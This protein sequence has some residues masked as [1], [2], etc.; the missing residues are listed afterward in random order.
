MRTPLRRINDPLPVQPGPVHEVGHEALIRA[1]G[2]EDHG[3]HQD[4]GAGDDVLEHAA[5]TDSP[6]Q[7]RGSSV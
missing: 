7:Q 1:A 4:D 5:G 2:P 3:A 6:A